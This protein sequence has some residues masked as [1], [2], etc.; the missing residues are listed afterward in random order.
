MILKTIKTLRSTRHT[1]LR[2]AAPADRRA[3]RNR[4]L[5]YPEKFFKSANYRYNFTD[6]RIEFDDYADS[7]LVHCQLIL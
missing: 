2:I 4:I 5:R 7:L 6:T 1:I 3:M